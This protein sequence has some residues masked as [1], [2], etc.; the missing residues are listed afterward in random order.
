MDYTLIYP[1]VFLSLILYVWSR[2]HPP[3]SK[4]T[5]RNNPELRV[6]KKEQLPHAC[7][8]ETSANP[9]YAWGRYKQP[10]LNPNI[11]PKSFFGNFMK[12][13]RLKR[14]HY[15]SVTTPT[16]LVAVAVVQIGYV[17]N[18]WCYVFNPSR[19]SE[20]LQE[21]RLLAPLGIGVNFANSSVTGTT[22]WKSGKNFIKIVSDDEK[23]DVSIDVVSKGVEFKGKYE[24][25]KPRKSLALLYPLEGPT[26]N[27]P[28]AAYTH[29]AAGMPAQGHFTCAGET[30]SLN[31]GLACMDWTKSFAKRETKWKWVNFSARVE[32]NKVAHDIGLNLSS[33]VYEDAE[34]VLFV[35][36][37]IYPQGA[38]LV[39]QIEPKKY[40]IKT[41][42]GSIDL[43]FEL[44]ASKQENVNALVIKD[45]F[46]QACG[47][48]SGMI[49]V[50]K[51]GGKSKAGG[52][53]LKVDKCLGVFEDHYALW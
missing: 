43:I 3:H 51:A 45:S 15:L 17:A 16:H 44:I 39:K 20:P 24:I 27:F 32:E 49:R 11:Q 1:V 30:V 12:D 41:D 18:V 35:D 29:K 38:L 22:E 42:N 5:P 25:K 36:G 9:E 21:F 50:E 2:P 4:A 6:L 52:M 33:D 10:I 13:F 40:S 53:E 28:R 46:M 8:R 48:Y 19:T 37:K 47:W 7:V 31:G 34:N 26:G 23:F 14:W